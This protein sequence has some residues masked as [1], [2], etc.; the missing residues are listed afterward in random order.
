MK[1]ITTH[2]DNLKVSRDAPLEVIRAAYRSLSQKYHPDKNQ[3]SSEAAKIM[4]I[5]NSAYEVLSDPKLRKEHDEWIMRNECG[6]PGVGAE[7]STTHPIDEAKS[8]R[9]GDYLAVV[10]G[11]ILG[12]LAGYLLGNKAEML[13]SVT[14]G[15]LVGIPAAIALREIGRLSIH[16]HE[17]REDLRQESLKWTNWEI[18]IVLFC[19]SFFYLGGGLVRQ[20]LQVL[21][22]VSFNTPVEFAITAIFNTGIWGMVIAT[23]GFLVA[24]SGIGAAV[25][26]LV[27]PK[28]RFWVLGWIMISLAATHIQTTGYESLATSTKQQHSSKTE[29]LGYSSQER[30]DSYSLKK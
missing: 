28:K 4:A 21:N 8:R 18:L 24:I 13:F 5:I 22:G 3:G 25:L 27:F 17:I 23:G 1:N 15:C 16:F 26:K 10:F 11:F 19:L 9:G 2:Y 12:G 29:S 6:I 14:V 20:Q 7:V 30:T